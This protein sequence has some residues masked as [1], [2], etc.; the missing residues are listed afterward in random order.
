MCCGNSRV[1]DLVI[2]PSI[3]LSL[4]SDDRGFF[5]GRRFPREIFSY[6][7]PHNWGEITL[8]SPT[9]NPSET[10]AVSDIRPARNFYIGTAQ[11]LPTVCKYA[12]T[13]VD[14]ICTPMQS[15][16]K[17]ERRITIDVPDLP[18]S[19]SAFLAYR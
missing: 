9:F 3:T 1:A 10:T 14:I 11:I 16:M 17:E 5:A 8:N 7:F 6:L 15:R 2:C 13:P 4:Q 19:C 18:R 12:F